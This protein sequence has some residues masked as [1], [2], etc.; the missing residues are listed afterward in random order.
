[1]KTIKI[2]L[3]FIA[4]MLFSCS[5]F[6]DVNE[7]P[8][9]PTAETVPPNLILAGAHAN[10]YRTLAINM[11]DLGNVWMNN[12]GANVNSFTGGYNDEF[13]LAI[14]NTFNAGIW[15][16]IYLNTANYTNIINSTYPNF[17]NHKAIAKIMK[18]YYFQ[19]IVD[20][21]GDAPYSEAHL[22]TAN[23]TPSY[24]DSKAIYRD[25]YAKLDEAIDDIQNAPST[26]T[27]VGSED[28][29]MNGDMNKWVKFANTVKLRLLLRQS[30]LAGVD[31]ETQ[32]YL[33]AKFA[34]MVADNSQFIGS[35]DSVTINPG[36][37]N[38]N[39][40]QQNPFYSRWGKNLD[41][42]DRTSFNFTRASHHAATFLNGEQPGYSVVDGRR[43]RIY[44]L[45]GTPLKVVGVKQGDS[46]VPTGTAPAA[47]STLGAGILSGPG[48]DG[49]IMT[50][51]E[52]MLLQAEAIARGYLTTGDANALFEAAIADSYSILGAGSSTAY[53]TSISTVP[54]FGYSGSTTLDDK[55]KAIMIQKWIALNGNN[56]IESWIEYTRTGYPRTPL[57]ITTQYPSKP[58]RIMYPNTELI[59]NSANVPTQT[60][61][62]V[63]STSIF[64]DVTAPIVE[65]VE[66]ND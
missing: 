9:S 43:G 19:Y 55:I 13:S 36:Y 27:V 6:L 49:Y 22:G 16:G 25:L 7:T 56:A 11:N 41:G 10:S 42:T 4:L 21:Y 14:N 39:D 34:E 37:S 53:A 59:G 44:S 58:N 48:Q 1:M 30:N 63:F 57:A 28:V 24:D 38:G 8:N 45:I 35:G 50:S 29:I 5:D 12:W 47:M 52:S 32:T 40:A 65:T 54:G 3:P 66:S 17:E 33:T 23:L 20:L 18:S 61:S 26:A 62:D 31:A 51:S 60:L 46:S 64:W 15:N 2:I